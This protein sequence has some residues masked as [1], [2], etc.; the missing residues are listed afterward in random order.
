MDVRNPVGM[1][2]VTHIV[3]RVVR[4]SGWRGNQLVEFPGDA[5]NVSGPFK[6]ADPF[7][8]LK[9]QVATV[10]AEEGPRDRRSVNFRPRDIKHFDVEVAQ[11]ALE[12]SPGY[13]VGIMLPTRRKGR[14]IIQ[15]I[16]RHCRAQEN[17]GRVGQISNKGEWSSAQLSRCRLNDE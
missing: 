12:L 17:F 15:A 11:S 3:E 2:N 10:P 9:D 7:G 13:L 4:V 16:G 6:Q 5:S 1:K 14:A 8:R